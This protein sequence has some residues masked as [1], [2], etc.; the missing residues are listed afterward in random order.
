MRTGWVRKIEG[1]PVTKNQQGTPIGKVDQ[2][3]SRK[4][5]GHTTEGTSLP[6]YGGNAPTFTIGRE[7]LWQHRPLGDVCG[8]LANLSSIPGETNR[9]VA[10]QFELVGFS[11]RELWLPEFAFQRE[12][13]AAI[14]EFSHSEL[15]VPKNHVWPDQLPSGIIATPSFHRRHKKWPS[16][17]GWYAHAEVKENSHWDWGS[18]RWND[19]SVTPEMVSAYAFVERYKNEAGKW[20]SAEV[21]PFFSEKGAL[22]DW[23]IVEKKDGDSKLRKVVREA[24]LESRVF[25]AKRKIREGKVKR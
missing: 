21:S 15:G 5:V 4:G 6:A 22:W 25:V 24:L 23:M 1:V 10:V 12:A 19:L 17:S 14:K 16:V 2:S 3:S 7:T 11:T 18:L 9:L 13:L 20:K 8:T